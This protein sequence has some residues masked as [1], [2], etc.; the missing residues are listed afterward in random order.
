[1]SQKFKK[2]ILSPFENTNLVAPELEIPMSTISIPS[3]FYCMILV[4]ISFVIISAGT[5]FCWVQGIDFMPLVRGQNGK[6]TYLVFAQGLSYQ[7]GAEGFI[8]SVVYIL[9]ALSLLSACYALKSSQA[10]ENEYD[11]F[12]QCLSLFGYSTPIWII[13]SILTFRSKIGSYFPNPFP[14]N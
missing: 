14:M 13:C 12:T 2:F 10:N 1:M 8:A 3:L 9:T 7:T 4:S 6:P 11:F 5:I